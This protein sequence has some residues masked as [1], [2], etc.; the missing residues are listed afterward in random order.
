MKSCLNNVYESFM[1][2]SS[3]SPA[4]SYLIVIPVNT[5]TNRIVRAAGRTRER[6]SGESVNCISVMLGKGRNIA[7]GVAI[8]PVTS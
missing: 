1:A 6:F 3:A 5:R 7:A 2:D 8:F 4:L